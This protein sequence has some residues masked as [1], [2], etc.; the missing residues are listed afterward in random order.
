[1]MA[2]QLSKVWMHA[3]LI[4]IALCATLPC[5]AARWTRSAPLGN[6]QMSRYMDHDA[7]VNMTRMIG[8]DHVLRNDLFSAINRRRSLASCSALFPDATIT[9]DAAGALADVQVV[10]VTVSGVAHPSDRDWVAIV[11]PSNSRLGTE[12]WLVI[13]FA[14]DRFMPDDAMLCGQ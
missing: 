8:G 10:T 14:P 7:A 5:E 2:V 9:T 12:R 3:S 6:S 11:S 4:C 13:V 1:M